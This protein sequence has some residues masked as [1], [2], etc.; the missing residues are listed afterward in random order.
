MAGLNA[1]L[2]GWGFYVPPK[3]LTNED[4]AR[5]I[6]EARSRKQLPLGGD[7]ETSDEWITSR[8]GIKERR[9]AEDGEYTSTM[10]TKASRLALERA[11]LEPRD[12]DAIIVATATPDYLFPSTAA[13]VQAQL[14]AP[15][16]AAFDVSA[17]CTGF[18]YG[19]S[20]A[21]GFITSG[22]AR[23]VL[24]IGAE[25]L[26]RFMDYTDRG[27]CVLFGDGAGAV[28]IEASNAS[29]GIEST[30]MHTDGTKSEA[31]YLPGGGSRHPASADSSQNGM[32]YLKMSGG[33]V[34]K[35][36]VTSMAEAAEE[37]IRDAGLRLEDI[38]VLVPHQANVRIIDGVA[39]RLKLDPAK[40]FVNV[41]RYGNTSAASIPIALCEAVEQGRLHRGDR[42]L[43]VAFGAGFTWGA[44]VLEWFGA[45]AH[46]DEGLVGRIQRQIEELV[47]R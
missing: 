4:V 10:S 42:V 19:L 36:A 14:G 23:T 34:F 25:T 40:V 1:V 44:A 31:L 33:E 15:R 38:D 24:V 45:A 2:T 37:A 39:R 21:R 18:I 22:T 43:V 16:A 46:R 6:V 11:G 29:V 35:I 30:V 5:L 8:T 28:V 13:L 41:H 20:V 3:V 12:V 7:F 47:S 26:S 9:N 32:H 27:T 17:A